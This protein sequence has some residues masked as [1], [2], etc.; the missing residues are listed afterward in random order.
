M[1]ERELKL[2][3]EDDL[4]ALGDEIGVGVMG[5]NGRGWLWA[6][7]APPPFTLGLW[8]TQHCET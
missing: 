4:P 5:P 3:S 6:G 8:I 1:L 2:G 7:P